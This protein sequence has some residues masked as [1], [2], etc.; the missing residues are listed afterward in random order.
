MRNTAK[1]DCLRCESLVSLENRD[2]F[3]TFVE[4]NS[5]NI[6]LASNHHKA[7]DDVILQLR[8]T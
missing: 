7:E 5:G 6:F 1:I 8:G 4:L 2:W 3:C